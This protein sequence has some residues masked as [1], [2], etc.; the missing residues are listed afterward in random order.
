MTKNMEASVRARLTNHARSTKRPFQEV[1]QFYGLERFLYRLCRSEHGQHFVLKGALLLRVWNTPE[2]RPTRDIDLLGHG[3]NSVEQLEQVTRDVCDLPVNDD[4]L[5]FDSSGVQGRR[6]KEEAEY[7]GVRVTFTGYL[8]KAR[9]PMQLDVGFG[10]T[11]HPAPKRLRYPTLLDLPAPE[12]RV[13]PPDTLVAEKFEA[14]VKLGQVNSRMKDFYDVWLL[15]RQL[16]FDG[17]TLAKAISST[18]ANRGTE[19]DADPVA[20]REAFTES[21]QT[22]A[23]WSAFARRTLRGGSPLAL[24]ELREPL[25]G[26]LLPVARSLLDGS[27]FSRS[28]VAPGPW[29]HLSS[30]A[31]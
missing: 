30:E 28:W 25:R 5:V 23:K 15:S 19:I 6:I 24:S 2:A 11:V 31:K 16:D 8:G 18:F 1:L 20:L 29:R 21:E 10:D 14:M 13:Y 27:D 9:I 22:R 12:L 7:A 4:G 17:P 26:F 3:P